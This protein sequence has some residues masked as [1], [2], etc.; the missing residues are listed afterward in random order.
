MRKQQIK[1]TVS[2][3]IMAGAIIGAFFIMKNSFPDVN[4][5]QNKI[6][7]NKQ[8]NSD[9]SNL[10]PDDIFQT[11]NNMGIRS[12]TLIQKNNLTESISQSL[13]SQ[14]NSADTLNQIKN[15]P[16]KSIDLMSGKLAG[17]V[18]P[19]MQT[20][21]DFVTTISDSYLKIS[22]DSS[23]SAKK[24]YLQDIDNAIKN[25]F[26][27]FTK[28]YFEIIIDTYQKLDSSSAVQAVSI[29]EKLSQDFINISVPKDWIDIHKTMIIQYKNLAIIYSAMANYQNDPIKGYIALDAIE[30]LVNISDQ[31][32]AQLEQ[33]AKEIKV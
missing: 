6:G 29:Y 17:D 11:A 31:I 13:F 15:N 24:K 4:V 9:L 19:K 3:V 12:N 7:G 16:D 22:N 25:N 28:N 8:L 20:D 5:G 27:G 21:L 33:K 1:T 23:D 10:N 32:Q 14:L 2:I 26:S 30:G 18:L